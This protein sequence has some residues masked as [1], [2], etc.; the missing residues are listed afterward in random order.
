MLHTVL[1]TNK[2]T[3]L[4]KIKQRGCLNGQPLCV[5]INENK[6]T[7]LAIFELWGGMRKVWEI[8]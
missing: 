3:S 1:S 5:M 2:V 4:Y 6:E 7:Y 8:I